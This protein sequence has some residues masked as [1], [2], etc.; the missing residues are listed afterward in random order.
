M[1][2][3]GSLEDEFDVDMRGILDRE[4]EVGLHSTR[5]RQMV[6]QYGGVKAAKLLL[7]PDRQL[8]RDTFGWLRRID[9][10]DL[11]ME[12]YV[13]QDKYRSLF[14]DDERQIAQWRLEHED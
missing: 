3:L 10:L 11:T 6:E 8:P 7:E 12:F 4:R 5:F 2:T 9:R 13:V 1:A 14:S